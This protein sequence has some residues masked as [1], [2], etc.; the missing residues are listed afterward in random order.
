MSLCAG[1]VLER[2]GD[3]LLVL[4]PESSSVKLSGDAARFVESLSR[5]ERAEASDDTVNSL[6]LADV[7]QGRRGWSRRSR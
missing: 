1:V 4:V 2:V 3:D 7:V 5:G 6:V